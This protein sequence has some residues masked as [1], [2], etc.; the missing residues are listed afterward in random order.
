MGNPPAAGDREETL[1]DVLLQRLKAEP[2][3]EACRLVNR[4]GQVEAVTVRRLMEKAF[5]YAEQ[6]GRPSPERK[7]IGVCLYHGLDLHAAFVGGLL[8]GHVPTMLPPPSP[9]MEISK[10]SDSFARM[11]KHLGPA[12]VVLDPSVHSRLAELSLNDL[13]ETRLIDTVGVPDT[14]SRE[15]WQADPDEVALLQHSSG[16]TGLQKGIALSHRAILHHNRVYTEKLG[17]TREDVIV[18]WLPLYHDMGF[19]ACFIL[20]LLFG[21]IFV[22]MSPFDWVIQPVMLLE[23]IWR[24]R[25]TLCWLPNFSFNFMA[26]SIRPSQIPKDLDLSGVR[27]W[28]NSSETVYHSSGQAFL[29]RFQPHGVNLNQFTASYA[30]AENV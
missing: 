27:A 9:R 4:E 25:G 23:Q 1:N 17:I 15:T 10:Y 24:Q 19:I 29:N 28:I 11:I 21:I 12:F 3:A 2:E 8:S 6:Y 18:S 7:I 22:E 26:Q 13:R 5:A 14:G 20:P 16:T 30:M